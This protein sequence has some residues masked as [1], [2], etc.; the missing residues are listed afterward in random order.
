MDLDLL[1]A[2]A[3]TARSRTLT[4]A[5]TRVGLSQPGLSRRLA[6]LEVEVGATLLL[7]RR[8]GVALTPAGELLLRTADHVLQAVDVALGE[9]G[10]DR[11]DLSGEVRLHASSIPGEHY[12]PAALADFL[13]TNP[14]VG[15]DLA[16]SDSSDVVAAVA[17]GE[18]DFGVC[19]ARFPHADVVFRPLTKDA[20][21]LCVPDEHPLAQRRS[22]T[23]PDLAGHPMLRREGGSGTQQVA[24][25]L[26]ARDGGAFP[27]TGPTRSFG[28]THATLAA[29][30]AGIGLAL[31]SSL[32]A[33]AFPGVTAVP[34][35][36]VDATRW[37][38]LAL[39]SHG[40]LKPT[41]AALITHLERSPYPG[42]PRAVASR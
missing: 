17:A 6:R 14:R 27:D 12:L 2:F 7:R 24:E 32:A 35:H 30:R 31:V 36:G 37:L 16:V 11:H 3:I 20:I 13:A 4:E 29:V 10:A 15:I 1:R 21:V 19:G 5:A 42:P 8:S 41:V 22:V 33:H 39:P 18:A 25:S 28:S 40:T 34:L 9:I 38:F 26:L 23:V